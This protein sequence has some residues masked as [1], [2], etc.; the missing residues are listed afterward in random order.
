MALHSQSHKFLTSNPKCYLLSI[1][2]VWW[3][4]GHS[5][6]KFRIDLQERVVVVGNWRES[7]VAV[8]AILF[9]KLRD[10]EWPWEWRGETSSQ[11]RAS[12]PITAITSSIATGHVYSSRTRYRYHPGLR[13][14]YPILRGPS[15]EPL[16]TNRSRLCIEDILHQDTPLR[17][18]LINVIPLPDGPSKLIGKSRYRI[19]YC[20]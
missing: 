8:E 4:P 2:P 19:E 20:W 7:A 14:K 11:L 5:S 15:I 1:R 3:Q 6:C 18:H 16:N 17:Y 12:L 13:R 9:R 10:D